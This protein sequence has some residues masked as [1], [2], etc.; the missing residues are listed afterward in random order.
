MVPSRDL[1][2][3]AA[4]A[5]DLGL[6]IREL[7][8]TLVCTKGRDPQCKIVGAKRFMSWTAPEIADSSAT[9]DLGWSQM[10]PRHPDRLDEQVWR[11]KLTWRAGKWVVTKCDVFAS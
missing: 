5:Q 10:S 7:S 8:E 11:M 1:Q 6:E 2:T 3:S 9:V 4:L